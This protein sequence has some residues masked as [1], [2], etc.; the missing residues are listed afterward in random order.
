M[1]RDRKN[2]RSAETYDWLSVFKMKH[3]RNLKPYPKVV[4][5]RFCSRDTKIQNDLGF[6]VLCIGHLPTK[7]YF[8]MG[9][10]GSRCLWAPSPIKT[11]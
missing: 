9:K 11:L 1:S 2:L 7:K 6:Y 5:L 3:Q 8:D 4:L 10:E